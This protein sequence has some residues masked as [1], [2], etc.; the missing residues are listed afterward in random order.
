MIFR[1]RKRVLSKY[2]DKHHVR[3]TILKI[4]FLS[5]NIK[6]WHLSL[7]KG[8]TWLVFSFRKIAYMFFRFPQIRQQF[9]GCSVFFLN[10]FCVLSCC[11]CDGRD[12]LQLGGDPGVS[13]QDEVRRDH[14]HLPAAG[15][16]GLRGTSLWFWNW[17]C[18]Q[19]VTSTSSTPA[20][21][22]VYSLS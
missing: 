20:E 14:S 7:K 12:G 19:F 1:E 18:F 21:S 10:V 13:G 5:T 17:F 16:E 4:V 11:R 22:L 15:Q 2:F 9:A 3:Q 6:V 8:L